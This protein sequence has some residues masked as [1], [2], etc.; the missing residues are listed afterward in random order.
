MYSLKILNIA[1]RTATLASRFLFVFFMAK[2]LKPSELGLYGLVTASTGYALYLVGLDFYTYTT[3]ELLQQDRQAWGKILK[4]QAALSLALYAV[5]LPAITIVFIYD[6]LPWSVAKW[7]YLLIIIEHICQ[8]LTRLFVAISE[9]LFSSLLLFLRQ[10]TWAIVIVALM[11]LD[12][13]PRTLDYVFAAW[14]FA[15]LL[16]I[17]FGLRRIYQLQLGGWGAAVDWSWIK[18]GIKISVPLLI[19][20]LAIRGIFTIDRYWLQALSSLES[21]GAYVLFIGIASTLMAFLEAGVF[22]FSYP[23][24]IKACQANDSAH[25]KLKLREMLTHTVAV[26]FAFSA[27]SLAILPFLLR[28][29]NSPIYSAHEYLYPWLL[30]ATIL[31][32]LSM[33]PHYA[34]YAQKH[35][36]PIIRSHISGLI[37]FCAS[38][39]ALSI[40]L[41][42]IAVPASLCAAFLCILL[43]KTI[44]LYKLTPSHLKGL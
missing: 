15:C 29:I 11:L 24:L 42:H 22:S 33:V 2:L 37:V 38:T 32:A 5:V 36:K 17:T 18:S 43:W 44:A 28:W 39:G 19:A 20:T 41:P 13:V 25:Y 27:I 12:V 4:N 16:A 40:K 35:D 14:V 34:L 9:Q 31:N 26:S 3:R 10:G 7:F 23:T 8:E 1:L 21:V 30:A 6:W